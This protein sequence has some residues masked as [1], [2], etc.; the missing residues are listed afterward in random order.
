MKQLLEQ[1]MARQ[2]RLL[3][4]LVPPPPPPAEKAGD[5][6]ASAEQRAA[7]SQSEVDA[8]NTALE[9]L[10]LGDIL[11]AKAMLT[12]FEHDATLVR[13]LTTLSRIAATEGEFDAAI[14]L[15]KRAEQLDPADRKV[16]RLLAQAFSVRGLHA[17][18]VH[19]CRRMAFVDP[20]APAQAYVDLVRAIYRASPPGKTKANSE[21]RLASKRLLHANGLDDEVRVRFAQAQ[22]VFEGMAKEARAHYAAASPCRPDQRDVTAKWLRLAD[23]CSHS[24]ISLQRLVDA[25]IPAYRPSIATLGNV[26]VFPA[27]QWAPVLDEGRVALSGYMMQRVQL[28]SENPDSPL[29]MN[30]SSHAE[31]RMP[32]GSAIIDT[33]A[34]LIGG[35]NQYYHNTVEMLSAL[36]VSE[37]LGINLNLPLV[38][39]DD[40]G[41]F[42]QEQ[43]SLLGYGPERLIKVKANAPVQF[44]ELTVPTRL[45]QGGRWVDPLVPQWYRRRLVDPSSPQSAMRR[46]YVSRSGTLRRRIANEEQLQAMLL[47]CGFEVVRPEELTV[48]EQID[49]FSRASHIIGASGAGLTNMLFAPPGAQVVTLYNKYFVS[50]GGDLYFDALAQACGHRFSAIHGIPVQARDGERLIDSD[51]TIDVDAVRE[52]IA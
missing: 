7:R 3:T 48:R 31:L 35:M 47:A 42:Q 19:Y 2:Q 34:L 24:D 37:E 15:L 4:Q 29:M 11:A 12:P 13:T 33:P 46:L 36:A 1:L 21:V 25:G 45:V 51:I 14:D 27:L 49:L 40:L 6:T 41:R 8:L 9:Q 23:W 16:W 17:E 28:R 50:G 26:F 22:Y 44:R 38:V 18:E 43:L 30:R 20:D 32:I 5:S 10:S 39:N 52:A